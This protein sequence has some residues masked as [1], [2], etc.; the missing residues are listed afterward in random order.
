MKKLR[1]LFLALL[2]G[3]FLLN[4][5]SNDFE[6]TSP[7]QEIPVVYAIL[8]AVDDAH[9]VRIEKAFLDPE[10]SALKVAQIA[11]SLYYPE[12]AISVYL[13][14]VGSPTQYQLQRVDGNLNGHPR[15]TG[16]F[17]NTPNWLYKINATAMGGELV[18]GATYR[19]IIKRTDGRPDITAETT[20]PK[21]FNL[22]APN[23]TGTPPKIQFLGNK[24]TTF[25][26]THDV[27]G[28][29]FNVGLT[30]PFREVSTTGSVIKYDTLHWNPIAN[31]QADSN[32]NGSTIAQV[33]GNDFY[34]A[35]SKHITTPNDG[36]SRYFG[37]V[38]I[39]VEGGGKEIQEFLATAQANAG[40]TGAEIIQT[41]SNMSEGYGIF[42]AKNY[43]R[44]DGLRIW[45]ETI[46]SMRLS[47]I[48]QNLNFKFQ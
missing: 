44:F 14:K 10:V 15:D 20:I 4:S 7:W 42:T 22:I 33:L 37:P 6:L 48:T 34:A 32:G 13:Q 30:I 2:T 46:D 28:V 35:L 38:S 43:R 41:Y 11:D 23:I 19:L 5:C 36:R 8:S 9:F 24:P 12:N 45:Q 47:P 29:Y 40:L 27:N 16:I 21:G 39:E 31:K 3:G 1:L 17:A 26:W 18:E 25:R